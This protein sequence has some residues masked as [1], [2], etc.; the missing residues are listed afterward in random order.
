MVR[1][2]C[3][4]S[5]AARDVALTVARE[6]VVGRPV[7]EYYQCVYPEHVVY[8]LCIMMYLDYDITYRSELYL[9]STSTR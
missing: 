2:H 7:P 4:Y 3:Y 5:A 8:R 6:A 1:G 9:P